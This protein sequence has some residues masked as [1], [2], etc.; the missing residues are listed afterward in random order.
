M[1]LL[2]TLKLIGN[3]EGQCTNFQSFA[4]LLSAIANNIGV[5][6][7]NQ[8]F[9]N[10]VIS[11]VQPGA[12]DRDKVWWRLSNSGTFVGIYTYANNVWNQVYPAPQQI[13]WL[14]GSSD[15][16]PAGFSFDLVQTVFSAPDYTQL[17]ALA[18]PN[19]GVP[20]FSY[21]PALYVGF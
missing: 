2:G 12:A 19:G 3:P 18:V 5:D 6:V 15:T 4:E 7:N 9:S 17:I 13:F 14:Y 1:T 20:P 21:Y 11:N 16:P 10:L 8:S